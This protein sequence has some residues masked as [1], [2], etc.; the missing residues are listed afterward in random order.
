MEWDLCGWSRDRASQGIEAGGCSQGDPGVPKEQGEA[1]MTPPRIVV[2]SNVIVSGFL[3][4]GV[5]AQVISILVDGHARCFT[6]LAILDEVR[7][8]LQRPKFGLSAELALAFVEE[9]HQLCQVV[10][11]TTRVRAIADDRDDNMVLECAAAAEVQFIVSGDTHL[12]TLGQWISIRM[13][14]PA[15]MVKELRANCFQATRSNARLNRG[16]GPKGV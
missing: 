4:G 5:P 11:P 2:D 3:F 6:S 1:R 16:V 9:F 12:Q 10:T 8:V 14:S 7:E 13:V 15:E